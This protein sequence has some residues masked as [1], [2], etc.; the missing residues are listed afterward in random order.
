MKPIGCRILLASFGGFG[1]VST[2][3]GCVEPILFEGQPMAKL[4]EYVLAAEAA[5][6]LGVSVNTVR[7]W[8]RDG[9]ILHHRN[10]ANGY[11][12]FRRKDLEQFLAEAAKPVVLRDRK[13][14]TDTEGSSE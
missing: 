9:K 5:C 6:I 14:S 8:A 13:R 1:K 11:R 4:N 2:R 7:N 3:D 10:P 12:M